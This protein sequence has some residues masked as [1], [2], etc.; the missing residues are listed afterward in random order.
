M[1]IIVVG[2][3]GLIGS[4]IVSE[5]KPRHEII[6]V[7]NKSGE[8]QVD[9]GS[10]DSILAMYK[11]IGKFDALVSAS[12]LVHFG[13]FTKMSDSLYRLGLDNKLMGQVNLVLLG[14]EYI[15]DAGSFTLTSGVLDIDPIATG[16][17]AS[18]V[19]GALNGFAKSAAI[20]MPRSIRINVVSPTVILEAMENYGPYFRGFDPVPVAKAAL[21]YSKSVEGHQTGQV[22]SV[23]Y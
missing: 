7:G 15:N 9:I 14:L 2:G 23:L 16:S 13:K 12:G 19:N 20:E 6:V 18:M 4:A 1:K 17:S 21:A 11:A 3:T 5:L 10:Q 22:Y 8:Y